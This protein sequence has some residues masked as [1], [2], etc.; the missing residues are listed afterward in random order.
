MI[1]YS[2]TVLT[3]SHSQFEQLEHVKN[4]EMRTIL[5]CVRDRL[6][7]VRYML[8]LSSVR[9]RHTLAHIK[10]Y[11]CGIGDNQYPLNGEPTL[12][13]RRLLLYEIHSE[14]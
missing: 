3:L 4:E 2:L 5:G 8:E 14:G 12:L 10:V 6:I 9:T 13:F 1:D 7:T 11:M